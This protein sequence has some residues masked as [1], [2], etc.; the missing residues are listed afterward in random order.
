MDKT[1]SEDLT[2][3]LI[4]VYFNLKITIN[5]YFN[6]TDEENLKRLKTKTLIE[7]INS[8]SKIILEEKKKSLIKKSNS[9]RSYNEELNESKVNEY[10]QLLREHESNIRNHIK[11]EHQLKLQNE[12][13]VVKIDEMERRITL[14]CANDSINSIE[15]S[16]SKELRNEIEKYKKSFEVQTNKIAELENKIK[17]QK[18]NYETKLTALEEKY[19]KQIIQL[20]AQIRSLQLTVKGSNTG[21]Y[22]VIILILEI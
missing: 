2:N 20:E 16:N 19:N 11:L 9:N 7:Y 5:P 3:E 1:L 12:A 15:N 10:E 13:L 14:L 4:S 18:N 8:L 21:K 17:R 6:Q 22:K